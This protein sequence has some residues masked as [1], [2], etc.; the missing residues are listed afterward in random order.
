M[1]VIKPGMMCHY[2]VSKSPLTKKTDGLII[3]EVDVTNKK[4]LVGHCVGGTKE[5]W[6]WV[7][8]GELSIVWGRGKTFD[9]M[10]ALL[11]AFSDALLDCV[12]AQAEVLSRRP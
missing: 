11:N 10:I 7:D 4:V 12:A 3:K 2:W 6:D 8:A 1:D 9:E 5:H